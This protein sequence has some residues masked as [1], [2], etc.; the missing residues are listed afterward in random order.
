MSEPGQSHI[1]RTRIII[2][3]S[4]HLQPQNGIL[5]SGL[6]FITKWPK[7]NVLRKIEEFENCILYNSL[8]DL[9][10]RIWRIC[11]N[12]NESVEQSKG[13]FIA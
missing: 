13:H 12:A 8:V 1:S 9:K 11:I 2:Q 10:T 7:P 4:A 6:S 5:M 3:V